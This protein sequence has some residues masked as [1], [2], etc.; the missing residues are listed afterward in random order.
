MLI[1]VQ[2]SKITFGEMNFI[3]ARFPINTVQHAIS[4]IAIDELFDEVSSEIAC[5]FGFEGVE[6]VSTICV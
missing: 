4:E 3:S 6:L 5:L 1:A 2:P